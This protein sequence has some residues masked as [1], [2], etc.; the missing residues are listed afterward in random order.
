MLRWALLIASRVLATP[1]ASAGSSDIL[2]AFQDSKVRCAHGHSGVIV[3]LHQHS[4]EPEELIAHLQSKARSNDVFGHTFSSPHTIRGFS[5]S[6]SPETLDEVVFNAEAH[7]VRAIHA[8]C[9]INMRQHRM[10]E[11]ELSA[12]PRTHGEHTVKASDATPVHNPGGVSFAMGL[13]NDPTGNWG[14]VWPQSKSI[15]A[16]LLSRLSLLT[17]PERIVSWA[18]STVPTKRRGSTAHTTLATRRA[19]GRYQASRDCLLA[20]PTLALSA[21]PLTHSASRL[22]GT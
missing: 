11:M 16:C 12:A 13:Q 5:A 15:P 8:D 6:F 14:C 1:V 19:K 9:L 10:K 17:S 2:A 20:C 7:G 4:R 3:T 18:A 22:A 21:L